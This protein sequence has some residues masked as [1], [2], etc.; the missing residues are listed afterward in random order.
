MSNPSAPPASAISLNPGDTL[1]GK[2]QIDRIIGRGSMGVVMAARHIHLDEQVAIKFMLP[3]AVSDREQVARFLREARAAAKIKNEHVARVMDVDVMQSGM[4]YIVMEYLD[5]Q[6][7]GALLEKSGALPMSDTIDYVVQAC[8]ALADAHAL[9]IIHRDFKPSNVFLA[10]RRD[11]KLVTKILDFGISK[12]K[13]GEVAMTSTVAL[14][15]SPAYMS[16]EQMLSSRDVDLRT[17]IW[18]VGVTLYQL[19]SGVL[20]FNG[21]TVPEV[22]AH[23]I[24]V[25]PA[26]LRSVRPQI[27]P[28]LETVVMRCL[29]KDR[30]RRFQ[31]MAELVAALLPFANPLTAVASSRAS[32]AAGPAVAG[33]PRPHPSFASGSLSAWPSDPRENTVPVW[34]GTV[35]GEHS[36][37]SSRWILAAGIALGLAAGAVFAAW[38]LRGRPVEEA[39][40]KE[41]APPI[42]ASPG[43]SAPSLSSAEVAAPSDHPPRDP[44]P[45]PSAMPAET[46]A[47][48]AV[49][50]ARARD[51]SALGSTVGHGPPPAR[52]KP[53]PAPKRSALPSNEDLF[54]EPK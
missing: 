18:A 36:R 41:A 14:M 33:D 22:C 46:T 1:A 42:A 9:G 48:T 28:G 31:N 23:V 4:P 7:L 27:P 19:L 25:E 32:R 30:N 15:G 47:P 45:T 6:D 3:D 53:L 35:N 10:R 37:R 40:R 39:A 5:G 2:Y 26:P 20:P 52:P 21:T 13:V 29:V 51:T 38:A 12:M 34:G 44:L 8:D 50:A 24:H 54:S 11:G 49:P 17:D 16:P 43:E